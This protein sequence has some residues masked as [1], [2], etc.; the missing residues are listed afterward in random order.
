MEHTG[1]QQGNQAV[2]ETQAGWRLRKGLEMF[3]KPRTSNLSVE[4]A[5]ILQDPRLKGKKVIVVPTHITDADVPF[6]ASV[7]G[8]RRDI[9]MA[10]HETHYSPTKD[11]I[12]YLTMLASGRDNY[13]P[14]SAKWVTDEEG[15]KA[16]KATFNPKNYD[17]ML[18]GLDKGK[19][20]VISSQNNHE[21]KPEMREHAGVG[22]VWLYQMAV[23]KYGAENVVLIPA[24]MWFDTENPHVGMSGH[25]RD[26]FQEKPPTHVAFGEPISLDTVDMSA[27]RSSGVGSLENATPDQ[28]QARHDERFA[29]TQK[30]KQQAEAVVRAQVALLPDRFKGKW[31]DSPQATA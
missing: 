3:V 17:R 10:N 4:H 19:T 18:A 31:A 13:A 5:E 2:S 25:D 7:V 29:A 30:I 16:E 15:N 20:V 21:K 12:M 11:P 26:T 23:E 1:E 27:L 8:A 14:V 24:A 28:I 6:V 9:L 22:N